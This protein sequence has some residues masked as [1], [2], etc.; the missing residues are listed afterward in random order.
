MGK[1]K[2]NLES[3]ITAR[4]MPS[5]YCLS[6]MHDP[7]TANLLSMVFRSATNFLSSS[8]R[9]DV[10]PPRV[11][12]SYTMC[13]LRSTSW[14]DCREA[15]DALVKFLVTAA[16]SLLIVATVL[17]SSCSCMAKRTRAT[18]TLKSLEASSDGSFSAPFRCA[19]LPVDQLASVTN[20]RRLV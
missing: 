8:G 13:S 17:L 18:P 20:G 16:R 19:S 6:D 11:A 10:V 1:E 5:R 2:T 12:I 3:D 15:A 9:W 14:Q 4:R 7:T